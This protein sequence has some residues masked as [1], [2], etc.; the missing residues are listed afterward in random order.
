METIEKRRRSVYVLAIVLLGACILFFVSYGLFVNSSAAMTDAEIGAGHVVFSLYAY[1]GFT[2]ISL[3]AL[4]VVS[5]TRVKAKPVLSRVFIWITILLAYH[6]ASAFF[7]NIFNL[8]LLGFRQ[9][10]I[11]SAEYLPCL[12]L[13]IALISV[14]CQWDS[15]DKKIS[16]AVSWV[17]FIVSAFLSG[18][19]IFYKLTSRVS[20]DDIIIHD[21]LFGIAHAIVIP[22]AL[23]FVFNLCR[24]KELFDQALKN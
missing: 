17:C 12:L 4:A 23:A 14:I 1:C 19:F 10:L 7:A 18:W 13:A 22:A 24:K 2:V 8:T 11:Y 5:M 21:A 20:D 6:F 16:H 9:A 3:A 15:E